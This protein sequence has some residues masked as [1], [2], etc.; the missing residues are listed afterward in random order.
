MIYQVPFKLSCKPLLQ[1]Y[2]HKKYNIIF[3]HMEGILLK[4][5]KLN[6]KLR[7]ENEPPFW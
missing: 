2:I 5:Q 7:G 6:K 4:D 1:S 3:D